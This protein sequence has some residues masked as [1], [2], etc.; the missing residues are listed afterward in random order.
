MLRQRRVVRHQRPFVHLV[1]R[2]RVEV[3]GAHRHERTVDEHRLAVHHRR[4]VLVSLCA[5]GDQPIHPLALRSEI[6]TRIRLVAGRED[7]HVD[8]LP[9]LALQQL[10]DRFRGQEVGVGEPD[11][12]VRGGDEELRETVVVGDDAVL[13]GADERRSHF[14]GP[15]RLRKR[16]GGQ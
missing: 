5:G 2:E 9:C 11:A 8:A 14:S 15:L 12:L 4:L 7:A 3:A 10:E 13:G 16:V 6:G 1:E